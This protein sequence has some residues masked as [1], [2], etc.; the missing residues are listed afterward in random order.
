M[1]HKF[2]YAK[3]ED[4]IEEGSSSTTA[5]VSTITGPV[6]TYFSNMMIFCSANTG[7]CTQ[8]YLST[9]S[10]IFGAFGV[11]L[12]NISQYMFPITV[13]CLL[14]SLLSLWIKKRDFTHKPFLLGCVATVMIIASNYLHG[15]AAKVLLWGGNALMIGAAIWNWKVNKASGLPR[16]Y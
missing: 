3:D 11:S 15:M 4:D 13:V 5:L 8:M 12:S 2:S 9:F 6:L 16:K 1:K 7:M 10:A 14:I